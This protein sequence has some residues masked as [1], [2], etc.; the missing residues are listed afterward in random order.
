MQFTMHPPLFYIRRFQRRKVFQTGWPVETMTDVVKHPLSSEVIGVRW[1]VPFG[2]TGKVTITSRFKTL[3][4]EIAIFKD[5]QRTLK[6]RAKDA[7]ASPPDTGSSH[8][9]H[10]RV[11]VKVEV[12][13][14]N[15]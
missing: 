8:E 2:P 3:A 9:K 1:E 13:V 5:D 15:D 7:R 4:A 11:P 10:H 12:K 14:L 6:P